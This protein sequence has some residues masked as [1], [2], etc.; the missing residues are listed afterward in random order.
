M[1]Y[2]SIQDLVNDLR[3]CSNEFVQWLPIAATTVVT[4]G[5]KPYQLN[6]VQFDGFQANFISSVDEAFAVGT[7][8]PL[9]VVKFFGLTNLFLALEDEVSDYTL[10]RIVQNC[11]NI[12]ARREAWL[13][14]NPRESQGQRLARLSGKRLVG[15]TAESGV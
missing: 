7:E 12:L 5:K 8:V 14:A 10:T 13:A 3:E 6:T 9:Y 15:V 11:E 2:T 4:T 1:N